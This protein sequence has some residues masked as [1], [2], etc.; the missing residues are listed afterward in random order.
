MSW[1]F[2]MKGC[3]Q[4][5]LDELLGLVDFSQDPSFEED[6][7]VSEVHE[8][9]LFDLEEDEQDGNS[10]SE[11]DGIILETI[12]LNEKPLSETEKSVQYPYILIEGLKTQEEFAFLRGLVEQ[13]DSIPAYTKVEGNLVFLMD[14]DFS[15]Q[16]FLDLHFLGNYSIV[17]WK[18]AD[19]SVDIDIENPEQLVKFIKL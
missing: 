6:D 10:N 7:V 5:N 3:E 17:L 16:V 18:S 9:D 11:S 12:I 14:F 4:L 15:L 2:S 13:S 1:R 8:E 19:V